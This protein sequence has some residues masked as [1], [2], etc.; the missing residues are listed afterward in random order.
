MKIKGFQKLTLIDYPGKL[1]SSIFLFGC[2]FKCGFCHNP[3][4]VLKPSLESYSEED[5]LNF[6]E[7]RKKYLDGVC[8]TGG[9]PLMTL[10]INFVEKIKALGYFIKIDTNGSFPEK[11]L[12]LINENLIDYV[13]MDIKSSKEKYSEIT[14]VDVNF[15]DVQ[16]V[17]QVTPSNT[18]HFGASQN[19]NKPHFSECGKIHGFYDLEESIKLISNLPDYEFR[20]TILEEYHDIAEIRKILEWLNKTSGKKI[21]RFVL[22]GFKN[23]GKLIDSKFNEEKNT[24]EEHLLKLK[25]IAEEYCDNVIVRV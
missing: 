22:Q 20:T 6:L 18:I 11:L 7:K 13:A 15:L 19:P 16:N 14:N 24:S 8:F 2:N 12:E 23:H 1:A 25:K 21:K 9:E 3:E 10:D 4:L 17:V 5:I